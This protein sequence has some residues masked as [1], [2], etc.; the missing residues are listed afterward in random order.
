MQFES[1]SRFAR[2]IR[3][4]YENR[5]DPRHFLTIIAGFLLFNPLRGPLRT[6]FDACDKFPTGLTLDLRIVLCK[7]LPLQE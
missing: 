4:I 1:D 7:S 6:N 3:E 2:R 5:S